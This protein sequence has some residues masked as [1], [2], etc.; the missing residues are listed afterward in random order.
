[1][2]AIVAALKRTAPFFKP[3][4]AEEQRLVLVALTHRS[5]SP[6]E[7]NVGLSKVGEAASKLVATEALYRQAG[8]H[9]AHDYSRLVNESL[10]TKKLA[11]VA[12]G[13]N[14]DELVRV[15]KG[16]E[17]VSDDMSAQALLALFGFVHQARGPVELWKI[18]QELQV[19]DLTHDGG[20]VDAVS[21]LS[22][23][24]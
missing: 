7:N 2:S 16:T 6:V 21:L 24:S 9:L 8:H 5:L 18:L 20:F 1:M 15:A 13:L 19:V 22:A 10:T 11:D 17:Y 3:R 4:T 23:T 14:L 12:R